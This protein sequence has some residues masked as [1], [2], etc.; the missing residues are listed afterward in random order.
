MEAKATVK[1]VRISPPKARRAVDLVRGRQV[2]EARRILRFSP[3]GAAKTIE[4]A[5]ASAVANA[6][7]Q[8]GVVAQNLVVDRAWVDEGPTLKRWRPRAYGRS[9]IDI[10]RKGDQIW[11]YIRTARPGI[12]IGRKGA[13]VDKIRKDVERVTK[14]RVDVKVEDMNSAASETR[15][16]T[17]ATLLAQGVAEQLAGRVSFRR[18]MRRAV[19]TAMRSG[20]LG[21]R[22]QCGGR[23]GGAEM[24]R[25]EWYREGRV[26]LHT[27]R[28][29]IDF[30]TAE[31]KT[32]FG[33]IGVKV[34]VYHGDE[35]PQ[36]EQETERLRARALAQV[37]SGGASTG[38]L[39]TDEREAAEVAEPEAPAEAPT[40][41]AEG[42]PAE[43]AGPGGDSSA[44]ETVASTNA[45]ADEEPTGPAAETDPKEQ[46]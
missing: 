3:L 26:P 13:E 8:P 25:R 17:D 14:K 5:L 22:V 46:A 27:L 7:Q 1:Y 33:Q 21:V 39:I 30:G 41:P 44:Q 28:A 32:T 23:L 38:A 12:V 36:A 43:A 29:K 34:W 10:E 42:E 4:K 24:S 18:A 40:A 45:V 2:E 31:G 16:E 15:P 9:S 19:Q 6:E 37:S 35:I 11:V 20:A